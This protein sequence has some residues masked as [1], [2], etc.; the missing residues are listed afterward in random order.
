MNKVYDTIEISSNVTVTL[1]NRYSEK[2]DF[3][4]DCVCLNVDDNSIVISFK[5]D[6]FN[7]IKK[8]LNKK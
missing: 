4:Y 1:E 6:T 2:K 8:V 7:S 3:Y 5:T